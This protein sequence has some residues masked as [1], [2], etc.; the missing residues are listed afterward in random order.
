MKYF[1]NNST[2]VRMIVYDTFDT[3]LL[4]IENEVLYKENE[5]NV[6]STV[7]DTIKIQVFITNIKKTGF[8]N[9]PSSTFFSSS[10]SPVSTIFHLDF[11]SLDHG[12]ELIFLVP[13][14]SSLILSPFDEIFVA[15]ATC[16]E[17]SVSFSTFYPFIC[18]DIK[19]LGDDS[20]GLQQQVIQ[21]IGKLYQNIR[22][23]LFL[24]TTKVLA[25]ILNYSLFIQLFINQD[26][27][28]PTCQF[29][30]LS[31]LLTY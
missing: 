14:I 6:P 27:Q 29:Q 22:N 4:L 23:S 15:N 20:E 13:S 16:A 30:L 1:E 24:F 25:I 31:M 12:K 21:K 2:K 26:C 5:V 7:N 8:Y 11:F 10:T 9:V 3:S 18:T 17:L 19:Y 28:K